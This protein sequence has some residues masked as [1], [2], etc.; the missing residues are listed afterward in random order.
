[1]RWSP[2]C[3]PPG[4]ILVTSEMEID[5]LYQTIILDHC[6]R[7]RNFGELTP[8]FLKGEGINPACGDAVT[9]FVHTSDDDQIQEIRFTGQACA[10]C[11]AST[12]LMTVQVKSKRVQEALELEQ[13][14]LAFLTRNGESSS[15]LGN[16]RAL[17]GVKKFPQ[18]LKCATLG[19]HALEEALRGV[20]SNR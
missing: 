7:P 1:M 16:L 3:G 17:G 9:V 5:D 19:W 15:R 13:E 18:R 20:A 2:Y 8:P 14:F 4:N 6:K 10:I 12:S 11:T